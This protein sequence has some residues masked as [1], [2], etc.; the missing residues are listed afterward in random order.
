MKNQGKNKM[1]ISLDIDGKDKEAIKSTREKD[2]TFAKRYK[3]KFEEN[4]N[5]RI[6]TSV[7][8]EKESPGNTTKST[9]SS[10]TYEPISARQLN[11][12]NPDVLSYKDKITA[13]HK[14]SNSV[15]GHKSPKKFL[16]GEPVSIFIKKYRG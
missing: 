12:S 10:G 1:C 14:F 15:L 11:L 9:A 8:V 4:N 5:K 7:S 2:N 6:N 3:E 13:K 16:L